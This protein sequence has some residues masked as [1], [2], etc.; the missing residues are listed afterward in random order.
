MTWNIWTQ[1][2]WLF[3]TVAGIP[4]LEITTQIFPELC[5]R[6][7]NC[8]KYLKFRVGI[9]NI[10]LQFIFYVNVK[11]GITVWYLRFVSRIV[12]GQW[13]KHQVLTLSGSVTISSGRR[14]LL[15]SSSSFSFLYI[16]L[17]NFGKLRFRST[18]SALARPVSQSFL[19]SWNKAWYPEWDT[20]FYARL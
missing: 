19:P 6:Y 3:A 11:H 18:S 13:Y 10:E 1:S 14:W 20:C 16:T 7:D 2:W 12:I 15:S 5:D 17:F 8:A 9:S 4:T